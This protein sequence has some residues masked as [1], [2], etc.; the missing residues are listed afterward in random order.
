MPGRM[1]DYDSSELE[2]LELAYAFTVHKSQ[3]SEYRT[4]LVKLQS[5]HYIMLKRPLLYTAITRAKERVILVGERR[6]VAIRTTDAERR[7]TMLAARIMEEKI[8]MTLLE[9]LTTRKAELEGLEALTPEQLWLYQELCYRIGVFET[10]RMFTQAVPRTTD[11]ALLASHYKLVDA[12]IHHIA[13]ERL[14]GT[15]DEKVQQHRAAAL[16][17]LNSV[18]ADYQRRF[19]SYRPKTAEQYPADISR[20]LQTVLIAWTQ[21]RNCY[22]DIKKEE[23][24]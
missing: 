19:Q 9:F 6:A 13:Q 5:A 15:K 16:Q 11:A 23:Q 7:G 22:I 1:A 14:F 3:G 2:L 18:I 20:T 4:V 24:K 21:H 12:Y 10:C 17:S 8:A